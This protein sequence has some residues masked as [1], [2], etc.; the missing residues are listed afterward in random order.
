MFYYKKM[1]VTRLLII[2]LVCLY[3]LFCLYAES[4]QL[5][6]IAKKGNGV[7]ELLRQYK[8]TGNIKNIEYFQK[9]NA[10]NFDRNGG[11]LLNETYII[12]ISVVKFDGHTIRST[13]GI[14][15]YIIAKKIEEYNLIVQSANIKKGKYQVTKELWVPFELYLLNKNLKSNDNKNTKQNFFTKKIDYS[16]LL[17]DS[18]NKIKSKKLNGFAF[19]II[20]G[21]GGPDPGAIVNYNGNKLY[22]HEYA[23]DVS[24]RLAKKLREDGANVYMIVQDA[25]DGIR[26]DVIL[27][28]SGNEKMINGDSISAVQIDR[29]KQRTDIVNDYYEKNKKTHQHQLL[30]EIHIDSREEDKRVDIFFYHRE[31]SKTSEKLSQTLLKTIESKYKQT[32]PGRGYKGKISTRDLFTLRNTTCEAVFIELGN[33]QNS[34]DQQRFLNPNNRQALANW[35][36]LGVLMHYDK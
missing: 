27:K 31:N 4:Q 9:L 8:L 5:T 30:I 17:N 34:I 10:N 7:L 21:H 25:K 18:N 6:T 29:L 35:I 33:I 1:Q 20:A 28:N 2:F 36:H 12:P 15:D 26:N 24:I 22:E 19:Y 32:Q 11:L 23:Y 14:N 16:Y 13:L 3:S